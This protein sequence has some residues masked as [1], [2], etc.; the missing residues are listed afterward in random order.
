MPDAPMRAL[1]TYGE[2]LLG[3]Y[4][5]GS[6]GFRSPEQRQILPGLRRRLEPHALSQSNL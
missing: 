3:T 1:Q 5:A 6:I 2:I 4:S